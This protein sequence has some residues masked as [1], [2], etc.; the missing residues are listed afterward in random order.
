MRV[1]PDHKDGSRLHQASLHDVLFF[2]CRTPENAEGRYESVAQAAQSSKIVPK[3]GEN[4][5]PPAD[6]VRC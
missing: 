4:T 2:T 3:P 1:L 6:E 5:A